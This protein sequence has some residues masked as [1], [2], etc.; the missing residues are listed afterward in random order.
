MRWKDYE[1]WFKGAFIGLV[2]ALFVSIGIG[3]NIVVLSYL[4][5]PG[6]YSCHLLTQCTE[7]V[8]SGCLVIGLMLNLFYG[9]I[10]GA[11]IGGIIECCCHKKSNKKGGRKK[12]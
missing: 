9:F 5:S 3:S 7:Q 8:C 4:S 11:I 6:L 1:T 2:I 10:I 12:K